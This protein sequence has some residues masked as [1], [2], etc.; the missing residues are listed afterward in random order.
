M[1]VSKLIVKINIVGLGVESYPVNH[2]SSS[3]DLFDS[4]GDRHSA[5]DVPV[6]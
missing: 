4:A 6:N 3:R 1:D 2:H 5:G